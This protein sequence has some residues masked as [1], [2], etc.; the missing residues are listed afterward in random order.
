MS[1]KDAF[2]KKQIAQNKTLS[3]S[4]LTPSLPTLNRTKKNV[5]YRQIFE[6][7]YRMRQETLSPSLP[8][9]SHL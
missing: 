1:L 9:M 7:I 8:F 6:K 2:Q 5:T 4:P 3:Y